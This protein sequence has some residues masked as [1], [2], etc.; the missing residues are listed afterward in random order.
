MCDIRCRLPPALP[1]RTAVPNI[2]GY[3]RCAISMR[4]G[5]STAAFDG[6]LE[7]PLK[8]VQARLGHASIQMTADTYRHLFP[9]DDSA[10]LAAAEQAF[11][12][13]SMHAAQAAER[14]PDRQRNPISRLRRRSLARPLN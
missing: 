4:H 7:L 3:M 9:R 8:L 5:A 14:L 6:G 13:V 12:T 1:R 10:E 2:R 11:I